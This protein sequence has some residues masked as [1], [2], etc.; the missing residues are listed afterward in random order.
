MNHTI[1]RITNKLLAGG[2]LLVSLS[3]C[4][5]MY[6][7]TMQHVP[8][9]QEQGDIKVTLNTNNVQGAYAV[10][11]NVGVMVNG[12][13]HSQDWS[14]NDGTTQNE[15][16]TARRFNVEGAGG[17]FKKI[18]ENGSFEAY[19]GAGFGNVSY[20][21]SFYNPEINLDEKHKFSANAMKVFVQP[22]IGTSGENM[23]VA[24]STRLVALKFSGVNRVGY[25]DEELQME[26]LFQID[27]PTYIFAEPALTL[28]Y[29]LPWM[30]IQSQVLYSAK[31]N[32]DAL[33]YKPI[34]LN[35]SLHF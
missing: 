34:N 12:S 21:N 16:F 1:Q 24:F 13:F 27:R 35:F 31:L 25:T 22:S 29:G 8:L 17:Y 26:D 33:N 9:L 10:T 11:E 18:G 2:L 23:E 3:G 20:D 4:K 32:A 6:N 5:T 7:P 15:I 28:R 19:G 14:V 30:K